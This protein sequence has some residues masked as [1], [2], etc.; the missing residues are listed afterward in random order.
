MSTGEIIFIA[1]SVLMVIISVVFI[2]WA[3]DSGLFKHIEKPKYDMLEEREPLPWPGRDEKTTNG[4]QAKNTL[5]EKRG[6]K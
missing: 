4:N 3:W 5:K 2:I 6:R 1:W